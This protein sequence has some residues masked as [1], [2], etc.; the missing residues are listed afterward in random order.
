MLCDEFA[1]ELVGRDLDRGRAL[2]YSFLLFTIAE[3]LRAHVAWPHLDLL[4]EHQVELMVVDEALLRI[5]VE[6][7]V[8]ACRTWKS[9][10][11][12]SRCLC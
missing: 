9:K 5:L 7:N 3:R 11:H 8:F 1:A 4:L 10:Q 2:S 6:D 12:A